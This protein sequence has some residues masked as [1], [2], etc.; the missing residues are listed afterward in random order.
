[1]SSMTRAARFAGLLYLLQLI[2]GGF[3]LFYVSSVCIVPGDSAAMASKILAAQLI[4]RIGILSDI[5]GS[6]LFILLVMCLFSLFKDIDK[7]HAMLMVVSV[8][9][10]EAF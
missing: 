10:A 5:V 8:S 4:Y 6:I 1:M 2:I 3:S 9:I 7:K